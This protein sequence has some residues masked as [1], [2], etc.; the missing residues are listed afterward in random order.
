MSVKGPLRPESP[1][2]PKRA[3][4]FRNYIDSLNEESVS[5]TYL[6]NHTFQTLKFVHEQRDSHLLFNKGSFDLLDAFNKLDQIVDESDPD[7]N[8]PQIF[9]ALQTAEAIR[10]NYPDDDWFHLVGLIHDLGKLLIL[11]EFGENPSWA[12]VGDTFPLGCAF[13]SKITKAH[14]FSENPDSYN[15]RYSSLYGI[16]EP[17]C[18][19][20]NLHMAW[21]HDEYLFQVLVHNGCTIPRLGLDIIR[22]HSFFAWHRDGAYSHLMTAEDEE[23]LKWVRR[24]SQADLYSKAH[25]VPTSEEIDALML[26]FGSLIDKYFPKQVLDW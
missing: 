3:E 9:H 2:V 6:L 11:P 20:E 18:G 1:V 15:P 24:F 17:H 19:L 23:T 8:L 14:Y 25:E 22:F 21:G 26:Y 12:V 13:S 10:K 4:A 7:N 16:Y 5:R